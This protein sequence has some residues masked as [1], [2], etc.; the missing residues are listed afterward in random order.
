MNWAKENGK[1]NV[2]ALDPFLNTFMT[3]T[4]DGH[5]NMSLCFIMNNDHCY[6]VLDKDQK[7]EIAQKRLL[8]ILFLVTHWPFLLPVIYFHF[9]NRIK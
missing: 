8:V 6:A 3:Y 5:I 9:I 4:T 7:F 1:I 2:F